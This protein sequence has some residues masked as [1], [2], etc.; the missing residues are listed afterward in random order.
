MYQTSQFCSYNHGGINILHPRFTQEAI[1]R[2]VHGENLHQNH[3]YNFYQG[4]PTHPNPIM[5]PHPHH[6]IRP[7]IYPII[8]SNQVCLCPY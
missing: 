7:H 8:P 2:D 4:L 5:Q 6:H 1:Q 3:P